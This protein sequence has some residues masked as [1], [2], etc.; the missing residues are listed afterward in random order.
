MTQ[1]KFENT[2][3]QTEQTEL[4]AYKTYK[5]TTFF[6]DHFSNCTLDSILIAGGERFIGSLLSIL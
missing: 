4:F 3:Q 1:T 5:G 2:N 6:A